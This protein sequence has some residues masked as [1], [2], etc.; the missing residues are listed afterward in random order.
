MLNLAEPSALAVA[1]GKSKVAPTPQI[2]P[3]A[4]AGEKKKV[5]SS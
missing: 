2:S 5:W 1:V 4:L 3:V